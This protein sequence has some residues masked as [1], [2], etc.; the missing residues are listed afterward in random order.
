M[1]AG[2][3]L[4]LLLLFFIIW[5]GLLMLPV[6]R[7]NQVAK[8]K[9]AGP[10]FKCTVLVP[11]YCLPNGTNQTVESRCAHLMLQ[12]TR[13]H[14]QCLLE[15]CKWVL[16]KADTKYDARL[17]KKNTLLLSTLKTILAVHFGLV[18]VYC[19]SSIISNTLN[20]Q[21]VKDQ[22]EHAGSITNGSIWLLS[23]RMHKIRPE[24]PVN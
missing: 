19:M 8:L 24:V 10:T 4:N 15:R 20:I 21:F 5:S 23:D 1:G 14:R 17:N 12:M 7:I 22:V 2:R 11:N 18:G 6:V 16:R 13:S 3:R 9:A